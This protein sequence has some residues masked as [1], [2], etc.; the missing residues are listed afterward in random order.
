[1]SFHV[2]KCG[3]VV[4]SRCEALVGRP[5][6][7]EHIPNSPFEMPFTTENNPTSLTL[8]PLSPVVPWRTGLIYRFHT[9]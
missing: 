2:T 1:M 7:A 6:Q 8:A 4:H 3:H 5:R 9:D